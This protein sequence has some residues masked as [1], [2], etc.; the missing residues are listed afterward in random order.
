ML[1]WLLTSTSRISGS[2]THKPL[3]TTTTSGLCKFAP[4]AFRDARVEVTKRVEKA[5]VDSQDMLGLTPDLLQRCPG[6]LPALRMSCCPPLA[7][8]RL[9]GLA[10]TDKNLV[11]KMEKGET[12]GADDKKRLGSSPEKHCQGHRGLA[13]PGYF[14]LDSSTGRNPTQAERHRASTRS[15]PTGSNRA[16]SPIPSSRTATGE[17]PA[18]RDRGAISPGRATRRSLTPHAHAAGELLTPGTFAFHHSLLDRAQR[19]H[20]VN[21]SVD[22]IIQLGC[23][24]ARIDCRSWL[25]RNRLA[26][27][28][29]P[30]RGG[31]RKRRRLA[32]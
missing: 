19:T 31:K 8:D 27:S 17:T 7:V 13:R 25:R 29:T 5:I 24:A 3:L 16:P 1:K 32:N 11:K 4:Q 10:Y 6:V 28:P 21:V 2:K 26:I 15:S 30:T 20:K 14:R 18:P 22:V 23:P 12:C 9:V